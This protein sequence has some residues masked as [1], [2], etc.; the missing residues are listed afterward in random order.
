MEELVKKT[1]ITAVITTFI[2]LVLFYFVDRA[3]D[4][5][6]HNYLSKTFIFQL[7]TYISLL[8]KGGIINLVI[9]FYFLIIIVCDPDLKC[10]W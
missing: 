6:A 3:I 9:A 1:A 5:W 2:Y 10:Q 8:A 7:G 4:I